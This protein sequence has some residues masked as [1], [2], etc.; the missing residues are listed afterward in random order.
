MATWINAV[1]VLASFDILKAVDDNG[2][3]IEPIEKYSSGLIR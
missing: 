1:S 2:V 3:I